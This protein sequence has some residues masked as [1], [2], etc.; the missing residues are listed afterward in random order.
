MPPLLHEQEYTEESE[1]RCNNLAMSKQ[2]QKANKRRLARQSNGIL[3][4]RANPQSP[5]ALKLNAPHGLL[6]YVEH[7][8]ILAGLLI[9][10]GIAGLIFFTPI[11]LVCEACLL[12][13]LHSSKLLQGRGKLYQGAAYSI[14]FLLTAPFILAFGV[15]ARILRATTSAKW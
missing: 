15:Y 12:L 5:P 9:I 13:A 1:V 7:P 14:L 11:L 6:E 2:A 3:D 4:T 8:V 10:G